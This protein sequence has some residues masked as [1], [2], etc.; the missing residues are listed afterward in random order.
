MK[1][2]KEQGKQE[3]ELFTWDRV[4]GSTLDVY[5]EVV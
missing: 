3:I 1:Y 5:R 4:A 2:D